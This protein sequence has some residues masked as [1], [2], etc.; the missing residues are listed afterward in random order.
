MGDCGQ[1][2]PQ[3]GMR[4]VYVAGPYSAPSLDAVRANVYR[5]QLVGAA[6]IQAGALPL[7]PHVVSMGIEGSLPESRWL[8]LGLDWLSECHAVLLVPGWERSSGTRGEIDRARALG[9]PV[10]EA[11]QGP[12]GWELPGT[13]LDWIGAT[14]L[15]ED[16][17]A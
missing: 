4:R 7:V 17:H 2:Q 9:L 6:V 12:N 10:W 14:R 3:N 11:Y 15:E 8:R 13:M 5:A 1:S 16:P